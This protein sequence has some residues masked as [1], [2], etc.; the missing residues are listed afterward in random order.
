MVI[1]KMPGRSKTFSQRYIGID[2]SGAKT[3]TSSLKGIRVYE[4]HL[5]AAPIE[6]QPPPSPR[7]YWT[8]HGVAQWLVEYLS[9]NV[10]KYLVLSTVFLLRYVISRST[11]WSQTGSLFLMIFR[12]I[13]LLMTKIRMSILSE[14]DYMG[15]EMPE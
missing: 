12:S 5:D 8:R 1:I 7:K 15:T 14:M 2:Y 10:P 3:P 13:G 4:G 6:V 11:H 9:E